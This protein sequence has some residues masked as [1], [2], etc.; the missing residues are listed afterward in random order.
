MNRDLKAK[1]LPPPRLP[2]SQ[3]VAGQ[4]SK[5]TKVIHE[6]RR[7]KEEGRRKKEE[8]AICHFLGIDPAQSKAWEQISDT[9]GVSWWC[10]R[11]P[12]TLSSETGWSKDQVRTFL[13][14]GGIESNPNAGMSC[15]K[16]E[17]RTLTTPPFGEDFT[18]ATEDGFEKQTFE[19]TALT[20][21]GPRRY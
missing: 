14:R 19:G 7:K 9:Q 16:S 2:Y 18:H 11:P 20:S 4:Q 21:V 15:F 17:Q 12:E 1:T 8:V 5:S 6:G 10:F 3:V 13:I